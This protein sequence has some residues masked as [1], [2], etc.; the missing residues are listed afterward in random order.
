[1]ITGKQRSFLKKIAHNEK[2]ITKLG[3]AGITDSFIEQ[4]EP[5]LEAREIVK[6]SILDS[7]M[8]SAAEACRDVAEKTN[9]EFVQAIGSKFTIY[10]R[11]R[12]KDN[13]KIRL[14]K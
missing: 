6:I 14:P 10:R 3:K 7:S 2:P 1:M 4:L 12:E 13:R 11:A 5:V 9:A 8:L